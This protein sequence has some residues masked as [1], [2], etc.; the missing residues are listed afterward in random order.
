MFE[1]SR[2]EGGTIPF[3]FE[4]EGG[5]TIT[6]HAHALTNEE[7]VAAAISSGMDEF[8]DEMMGSED[9]AGALKVTG[10]RGLQ[11]VL[12]EAE[13]A[14]EIARLCIESIEGS[15]GVEVPIL[16]RELCQGSLK[17]LDSKSA[18]LFPRVAMVTIGRKLTEMANMSEEENFPSEPQPT[19]NTTAS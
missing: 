11:M 8:A 15:R 7:I 3:T 17:R 1:L 16:T 5:G 14:V 13:Q 4:A 18:G 6:L 9:G 10:S 19:G 2:L 12:K